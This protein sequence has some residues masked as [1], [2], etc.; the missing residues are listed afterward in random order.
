MEWTYD[1]AAIRSVAAQFLEQAGSSGVFALH[2]AMGAGKT[3]FVHA[4]CDVLGVKD[5]VGSPTFSLINEYSCSAN[6]GTRPIYH[7]DLYRVNS[8]EEAVRAGIEDVLFSGHLC[9][10]EWPEKAPGI[11]PP[12]T[13]HIYLTPLG[14]QT[15]KLEIRDN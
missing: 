5:A 6:G 8:E 9:L 10:V 7:I 15:R 12:G 14:S 4:V 1:L 11:F 3:S 2:G 13:R